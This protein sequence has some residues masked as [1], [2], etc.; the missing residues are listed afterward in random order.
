[1]E[2]D[3]SVFHASFKLSELKGIPPPPPGC[4]SSSYEGENPV[5]FKLYLEH[6]FKALIL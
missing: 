6:S 3:C 2:L 1:M 5:N 4:E